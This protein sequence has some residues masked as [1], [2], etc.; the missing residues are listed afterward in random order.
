MGRHQSGSDIKLS[1]EGHQ[2]TH[3]DRLQLMAANVN[4]LLP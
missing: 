2:L 4:L 3:L 1:L